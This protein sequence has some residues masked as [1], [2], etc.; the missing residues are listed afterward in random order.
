MPL[1]KI[2][3]PTFTVKNPLTNKGIKCRPMLVKE[4]KVLLMAKQAET[5]NDQYN[6]VK[7]I[8]NNCVLD[9]DF[10]IDKM[11]FFVLELLFLR[12][13][14]NSISNVVEVQYQMNEDD[15]KPT[16]YKIALDK[17]EL[18]NIDA[19]DP[20]VQIT[21]SMSIMLQ[22]PTVETY[23]NEKFFELEPD[24][25]FDYILMKS[26]DKIIDGEEIFPGDQQ[27]EEELKEFINSIP[28]KKYTE[29]EKFFEDMPSLYYS[30]ELDNK[31][32][33]ELT[34]LDDFFMLV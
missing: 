32:K 5:R 15:E 23:T 25:A 7:Q 18:R 24:Q 20:C 28:A 10:D 9:E 34:S 19:K 4:E 33:M 26:I 6:A 22:Y 16:T 8:V 27:T 1:P 3:Y 14:S 30:F 31:E 21:D 11:P 12:I 2:E 29:I 17:V 13:R